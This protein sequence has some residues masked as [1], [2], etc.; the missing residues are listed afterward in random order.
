MLK[1]ELIN[2]IN[3]IEDDKEIDK[4]I[5]SNGFAKPLDTDGF[6]ELLA[7]NKDIQGL[8]DSKVTKGIETF[9]TNTMPKLIDAEVLKRS[10]AAETPEA[11]AIRELQ[12]KLEKMEKEKVR[13]EMVA[14][15]KDTL[16]E[17]NIPGTLIDFVLGENE[18]ATNANITLFENSM[19]SYVNNQ[20][21]NK[22]NNGYKPPKEEEPAAAKTYE[23]LL[24]N[25]NLSMDE[26]LEY[27]NNNN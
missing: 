25:D 23:S 22:L 2:L 7:S 1:S 21:Q 16:V 20:V 19:Q 27:F 13:A 9:K 24:Q 15:F 5:L 18:E 12:E 6:K 8:V 3:D 17:K 14:K 10:G 4:I 11:K 26:A